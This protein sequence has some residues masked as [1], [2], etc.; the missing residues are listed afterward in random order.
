MPIAGTPNALKKALAE[1]RPQVGIWSSLC[2]A[3]AVE[4]VA[5]SAFD[6]MLID[7]EHAPNDLS[8][9]VVQ[10]QAAAPYPTEAVVRIPAADPVLIK[11]YLDAGVRSLLVPFVEDA[12]TARQVVAATRYPPHGFRGV[13]VSHRGNRFGR[14]KTY[15]QDARDILLVAVQIETRKAADAILDIAAVEGIDAVFIGPSDLS[16]D[17]GH[18]GNAA[19]PEVQA[20]IEGA[21]RRCR[22]A[23][24]PIGILAPVQADAKRYLELGATMVAV[25]SDL[26]LLTRASDGLAGAFG[27]QQPVT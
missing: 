2:S 21:I 18:L 19:H 22:E 3:M 11:R 14:M 10:L 12:E 1:G 7:S 6:W 27:R 25:G 20:V 26:G 9:I 5:D 8:Q 16:A 17:L 24:R 4:V 23:G 15:L 13:S